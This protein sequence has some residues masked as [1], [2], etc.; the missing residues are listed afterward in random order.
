MSLRSMPGATAGVTVAV[1]VLMCAPAL[2]AGAAGP[3]Q[4]SSTTTTTIASTGV[5]VPDASSVATP[6]RQWL[7]LAYASR[8]A[9]ETL[10]LYMPVVATAKGSRKPGLIVYVHGGAWLPGE[11]DKANSFSLALVN[12]FLTLGYAGA[13]IDYRLSNEAHFPAQIE[14]VKAA[15]RWLRAHAARY[16]YNP[17][18]VAAMGDSAGGQLVALLGAS[19]GVPALEGTQ[20]GDPHISSRVAGVIVLYPD[21]NFLMED[22]WL[23]ENPACTGKYMNPNL[24]DSPASQY[25]GGPVQSAVARARAADPITYITKARQTPKFL[26]AQGTD[27]CTVPYQGSV[28]LYHAL[29]KAHGPAAAQ[30]LLEPGYGHYPVFNYAEFIAPAERLLKESI[31]PGV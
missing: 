17:D 28:A 8:S 13:S 29:V 19:G 3:D 14:D 1:F 4:P 10:D 16:G 24:A 9:D 20:L 25:L 7:N 15:V 23:S 21:V 2:G 26:I 18:K 5:D 30:L 6:H 11:G 22:T 12:A 27:D 31:G